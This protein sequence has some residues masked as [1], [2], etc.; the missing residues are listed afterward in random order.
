[1][2]NLYT[3]A[4]RPAKLLKPEERKKFRRTDP[5]TRFSDP[6]FVLRIRNFRWQHFPAR[7]LRSCARARAR[8][9]LCVR[10]RRSGLHSLADHTRVQIHFR[11]SPLPPSTFPLTL[12]G[13]R[14]TR[15]EPET[16][17]DK[18]RGRNR[19]RELCRKG[20]AFVVRELSTWILVL[21][22]RIVERIVLMPPAYRAL[23]C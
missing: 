16:R 4:R 3:P 17:A 2:E 6:G 19:K 9:C 13:V 1:M 14:E 23:R 11:L 12:R 15:A 7:R 22:W 18:S 20:F 5:R 8:V 10:V 21:K